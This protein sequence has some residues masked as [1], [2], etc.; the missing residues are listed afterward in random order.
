MGEL[1]D[2]VLEGRR[3]RECAM[4]IDGEEPGYPRL[5]ADCDE[6]DADD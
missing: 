1:A 6:G 5:C 4:V 2:E 3:C